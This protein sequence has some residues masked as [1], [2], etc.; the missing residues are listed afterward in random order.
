[1]LGRLDTPPGASAGQMRFAVRPAGDS[2]TIDP[3]P[4]LANWRQLGA[5]LHPRGS[6]GANALLGATAGDVLEMSKAELELA[7]LSDPGIQARRV[8][9]PRRGV[10]RCRRAGAGGAGVPLPQRPAAD[11]GGAAVPARRSLP[12]GLE[13][14]PQRGRRGGPGG[15]RPGHGGGNHRDQRGPDRRPPGS[16]D[17]RRRGDPHAADPQRAVRAPPDR[18][19]G[20][21]PGSSHHAGAPLRVG[22]HLHRLPPATPGRAPTPRAPARRRPRR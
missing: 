16:G 6:K 4:L 5:A 2:G 10:R 9:S 20:A 12:V 3:Q 11:G 14:R 13:R 22:P 17:G 18:E 8:R 7:V 1:M 19:P 21:V 15:P